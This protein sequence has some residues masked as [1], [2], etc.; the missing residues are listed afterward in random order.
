MNQSTIAQK[1]PLDDKTEPVAKKSKAAPRFGSAGTVFGGTSIAGFGQP[2]KSNAFGKS[3]PRF[4]KPAFGQSTNKK[5]LESSKLNIINNYPNEEMIT[6]MSNILT[7]IEGDNT[8]HFDYS[9]SKIKSIILNNKREKAIKLVNSFIDELK[10]Y[11][12]YDHFI[13]QTDTAHFPNISELSI[14]DILVSYIIDFN[15][16]CN[17]LTPEIMYNNL[18]NINNMYL[19][20]SDESLNLVYRQFFKKELNVKKLEIMRK[21]KCYISIIIRSQMLCLIVKSL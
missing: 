9:C 8:N 11:S 3:V 19:S 10:K 20:I 21:Y 16:N 6:E 18:D 1:R 5:T 7:A 17:M 2:A 14:R 13:K 12:K 15:I 4:G